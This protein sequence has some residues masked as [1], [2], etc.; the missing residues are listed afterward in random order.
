MTDN[1]ELLHKG[2]DLADGEDYHGAISVFDRVIEND[3]NCAHA[4]FERG[5]AS[6]SLDNSHRAIADFDKALELNPDDGASRDWRAKALRDIGDKEGAALEQLENLRRNPNGIHEGMGVCP[7]D[8]AECAESFI[9]IGQIDK[10]REL[11]E[12]YFSGPVHNV[13][14]YECYCT[15][16]MR[17]FARLLLAAEELGEAHRYSREA[18]EHQHSCPADEELHGIILVSLGRI[19][20]AEAIYREGQTGL[21]PGITVMD[22]LRVAIDT[23][24]ES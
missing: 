2:I 17:I 10:A 19:D 23:T 8:W 15:A 18:V 21:P 4:Y 22:D 7:Q 6:L 1:A 16:P 12:E 13:T 3:P 11:L 24:K 20:E 9:A 5:M 14:E